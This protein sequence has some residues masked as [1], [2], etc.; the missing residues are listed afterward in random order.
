MKEF[1]INNLLK[2]SA[3]YRGANLL[4]K[5]FNI[6]AGRI[7]SGKTEIA[8][9]LAIKIKSL[10]INCTLFDMDVVKPYIRIRDIKEL[11]ASYNIKL[12]APP[13]ITRA[14]DL[15]IYPK[16]IIGELMERG[17]M[18]IL[19]VGGD[20]YGAGSIAQFRK[21]IG[22]SYNFLFVVNTR[23]PDTATK[24]DIIKAIAEIQNSAKMKITHIV[25]NTNLRWKTTS[26]VIKEGFNIV[27]SVSDE[28]GIPI[29]FGGIDENGIEMV[30][31]IDI[32]FLPLKLFVNPLP[33]LED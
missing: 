11:F 21:A 12:V 17:S 22:E 2:K 30:D 24:K 5:E 13:D 6:F 1:E 32:P 23:R 29:M 20:S 25:F 16:F 4:N 14:I 9:N 19:D 3:G 15:P 27:K 33:I 28:T 31:S 7:G 18:K 10:G 26:D 8:I